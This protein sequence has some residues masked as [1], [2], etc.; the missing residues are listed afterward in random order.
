MSANRRLMGVIISGET[1]AAIVREGKRSIAVSSLVPASASFV[2]A[3]VCHSRMSFVAV[4]EDESFD[5]VFSGYEMPI[6]DCPCSVTELE[7][8]S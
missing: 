1:I 2:T 3:Y 4:F 7:K 5:P 8:E 6:F